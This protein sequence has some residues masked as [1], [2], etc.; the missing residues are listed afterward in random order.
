M[1]Y[2]YGLSMDLKDKYLNKALTLTGPVLIGSAVQQINV[3]IDRT[4]ASGLQEGSISALNY[5]SR[6]NDLIITVFVM[7]ITTVIFPMLSKAFTKGDTREGK[8]LMGEGINII[9]IITVPATIGIVILAE[10]AIKVFFQRGAFDEVATYMTSQ[11]LIYYSLGLV[12][13]SLR[14]M[15]NKVFYSVQDTTTPMINGMIAV[16]INVALNYALI[17]YMGHAGLALATSI[18][19]TI[20]TILLFIDL[21][22]KLGKIGL[23]KY[24]VCFLKTL[25][26]SIVMGLAVYLVYFGLTGLLPNM[27]IVE[28]LILILSVAVGVGIY[29]ILCSIFKIKEM[30][31]IMKRLLKK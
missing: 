5:A 20:T 3:I 14:L 15:L 4:L 17:G 26:A 27:F 16:G 29:F 11:A 21:R 7:A 25:A 13:S 31:I 22:K 23:K 9:L 1:G 30:R 10:P 6:V 28:L 2:S 18:S 19:A 24:L 8:E 12:G